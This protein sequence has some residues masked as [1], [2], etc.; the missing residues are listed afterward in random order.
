MRMTSKESV[1]FFPDNSIDIL[2]IDGNHS[3]DPALFDAKNWLPKVRPGG[4]IWFDDANWPT[5]KKAVDYLLE[6][7]ELDPSSKRED[8]YLLLRKRT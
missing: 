1:I 4:Y 8:A 2:H 3:E 7:C 5:T 6:T